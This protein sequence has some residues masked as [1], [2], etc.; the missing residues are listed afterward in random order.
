M[1]P[2][3]IDERIL[4]DQ[5]R[6]ILLLS[7]E[8]ERKSPEQDKTAELATALARSLVRR[9]GRL[10]QR[11][12]ATLAVLQLLL[13]SAVLETVK[14]RGPGR[15]ERLEEELSARVQ[16]LLRGQKPYF[17]VGAEDDEDDYLE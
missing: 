15:N 16:S 10:H 13:D 3:A 2:R 1:E 11:I 14:G 7:L 6:E 9:R 12:V 4:S 8:E 5:E 17:T